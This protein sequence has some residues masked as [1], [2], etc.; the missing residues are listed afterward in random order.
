MGPRSPLGL[1]QADDGF[2]LLL[3][4]GYGRNSFHHVVETSTGAP[5]L[6]RRT[7]AY[8]VML[9]DGRMVEGRAW[10]W[11]ERP[12]PLTDGGHYGDLMKAGGRQKE[13]TIGESRLILFRLADCYTVVSASFAGR[14][15]CASPMQSLPDASEDE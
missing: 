15:G 5:C 13:A 7:E 14:P 1:L 12:C 10:S 3:G 6:G 4:V 2:C 11:R 8:P 9:A